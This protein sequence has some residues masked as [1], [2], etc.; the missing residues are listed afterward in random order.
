[1][2]SK[3]NVAA[4][5][6]TGVILSG[7]ISAKICFSNSENNSK[8]NSN[9]SFGDNNILDNGSDLN[10]GNIS[11]E[12]V[13]T[14][15]FFDNVSA[16]SSDLDSGSKLEQ[17]LDNNVSATLSV[18][19]VNNDFD[20]A[21]NVDDP[22]EISYN[23]IEVSILSGFENT[24]NLQNSSIDS[25]NYNLMQ[26]AVLVFNEFNNKNESL[27]DVL[28]STYHVNL[29]VDQKARYDTIM[30]DIYEAYN[31]AI[32]A[33]E[34]GDIDSFRFICDKVLN[35][36]Y[37]N[38]GD[39]VDILS[40]NINMQDNYIKDSSNYSIS[41]TRLVIDGYSIE[42]LFS[43]SE[44]IDESNIMSLFQVSDNFDLIIKEIPSFVIRQALNPTNFTLMSDK[45]FYS[46]D[47][48]ELDHKLDSIEA[49][50]SSCTGLS[51]FYVDNDRLYAMD[52]YGNVSDISSSEYSSEIRQ[53]LKVVTC[54]KLSKNSHVGYFSG[55]T[56]NSILSQYGK[57]GSPLNEYVHTPGMYEVAGIKQRSY[58][59]LMCDIVTLLEKFMDNSLSDILES[60]Y[61][62]KLSDEQRARYDTILKDT[63]DTY[64][65][66][67]ELY[68]FGRVSEYDNVCN[69]ILKGD[70]VLN[71]DDLVNIISFVI[72]SQNEMSID[73]NNYSLSNGKLIIDG[74]TIDSFD[75]RFG[76][77]INSYC[78]HIGD[79][80]N[81][82]F[83]NSLAVLQLVEVPRAIIDIAVCPT[84]FEYDSL[85]YTLK[86]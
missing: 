64:M 48:E 86:R 66:A 38:L 8:N 18:E 67:I 23:D 2:V 6:A 5:C 72:N 31:N 25:K 79:N 68:D 42:S 27:S 20:I 35:G 36:E 53:I 55:C 4:L 46:Y 61:D 1:M 33:Y 58:Y 60:T 39:L 77:L 16:V 10:D 84:K 32:E 28:E 70:N 51:N 83:L 37:L 40:I 12:S 43:N 69:D 7:S 65:H 85:Q 21:V 26:D 14:S 41:D 17:V 74:C 22:I 9:H 73:S 71:F 54:C 81:F 45:T 29:S 80:L 82:P 63:Y 75:E 24:N 78:E 30:K 52:E 15:S 44:G 56:V 49:Y 19:S 13:L 3:K 62:G 59:G 34:S 76:S 47:R 50:Y 11:S 57:D